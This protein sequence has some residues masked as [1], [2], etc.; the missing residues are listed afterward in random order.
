VK[1][2]SLTGPLKSGET[3]RLGSMDPVAKRDQVRVAWWQEKQDEVVDMSRCSV[4]AHNR[5]LLM[6]LWWFTTKPSGY[7]VEPQ[8]QD[9]RLDGLRWDPGVLR[10]FHVGDMRRDHGAYVGRTRTAA[11]AW[12][13]DENIHVLTILPP[14]GVYLPSSCRGSVVIWPTRRDF[15]YIALGLDGNL[16][17]QTT[18]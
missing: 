11:K 17:I 7:L 1:G 13:L 3:S 9:R 15:T 16:S 12:P 8:S 4:A 18:S 14:M 6:G 10:S 5:S 2:L